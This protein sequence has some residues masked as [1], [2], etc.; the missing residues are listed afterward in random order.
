MTRT[1]YNILLTAAAALLLLTLAACSSAAPSLDPT[2]TVAAVATE[3]TQSTATPLSEPTE[4]VATAEPASTATPKPAAEAATEAAP[5]ATPTEAASPVETLLA[6]F[7]GAPQAKGTVVLLFGRV[8]DVNGDPVPGAAVEIWHTDAQGIYDHPGDS[9]TASRDRSFQFYGTSV[10]GD[11]G[12]YVFRTI[13]PGYYEPRPKHIHVKVKIDGQ[14]ALTTQFYFEEDRADLA[15]EGVFSQA[16][17]QGDLLVL[18]AVED[19]NADV[20]RI[21]TAD[22]V[23][24][25]GIGSGT[26]ALTPAQTEGPYYP[27]VNV[28]EFDND[29]TIVP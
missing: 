13:E 6:A 28:A 2:A 1:K 22:L 27:V 4:P 11:D 7:P 21:L 3:I 9:D 23:I 15:S 19:A 16:G 10:T 24:D 18:K 8:L 12:V 20:D 14:E 17:S 29:L 26:L 25:T 5:Q